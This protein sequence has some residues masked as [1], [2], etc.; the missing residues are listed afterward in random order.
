[1]QARLT[2]AEKQR[3][4]LQDAMKDVMRQDREWERAR[5]EAGVGAATSGQSGIEAEAGVASSGFEGVKKERLIFSLL[6]AQ[7]KTRVMQRQ[8]E[9]LKKQVSE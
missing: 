7:E 5:G 8:V 1:M 6:S 9:H 2:V 3:M 4:E